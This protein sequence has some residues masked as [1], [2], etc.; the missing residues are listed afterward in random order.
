MKLN[1]ITTIELSNDCNLACKY[2]INRLLQKH[3]A[4][5][6]GVMADEVFERSLH[7]LEVLCKQGT[8]KEVNLNGNG[9]SFLDSD[10]VER[11]KAVREVMGNRPIGLSTNAVENFTITKVTAL[12]EAGLTQLDISPHSAYHAR[13][14]VDI[15]RAVGIPSVF[16][17]APVVDSHNWAGQLEGDNSIEVKINI[18]C[19]PLIEGRGYIQR[20]GFI[21][22]CCY[23]YQ[24]LGVFGDVF[25][26]R[27]LER[28]VE[29]YELCETCH[30]KR[31]T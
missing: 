1:T 5:E 21:T 28:E 24:N 18:I 15:I 3:P 30:Q 7:W 14:A 9:E 31:G 26:D 4:R 19:H 10:L 20:E 12:K 22:P 17:T 16:N 29:A 11:V 8:Q 25:D 23:D 13:R 27:L 6:V 2:C